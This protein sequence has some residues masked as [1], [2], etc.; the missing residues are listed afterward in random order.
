MNAMA[1]ASGTGTCIFQC[2]AGCRR[3]LFI[4]QFLSSIPL[5]PPFPNPV[6]E[7][8]ISI[9]QEQGQRTEQATPVRRDE[10][11]EVDSAFVA[12]GSLHLYII[13]ALA[14]LFDHILSLIRGREYVRVFIR[15]SEI[16]M[17]RIPVPGPRIR[18]SRMK[19]HSR[20][21]SC[22]DRCRYL[23]RYKAK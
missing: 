13:S 15:T 18:V 7:L 12:A 2:C 5:F 3:A 23:P 21:D 22:A 16:D 4:N 11:L 19:V 17:S 6:S 10:Q 14:S 1:S 9:N 8:L 20:H